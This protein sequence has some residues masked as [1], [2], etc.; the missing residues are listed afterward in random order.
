M[1]NLT[2]LLIG[3]ISSLVATAIFIG[4]S[5]L[6]RRVLLPWFSDKIYRGVRIDGRWE[7]SNAFEGE[8]ILARLDLAQKGD[9]ITGTYFHQH[10]DAE[11]DHYVLRGTLRDSYLSAT[12]HPVSPHMLDAAALLVHVHAAGGMKLEGALLGVSSKNGSVS[13][14]TNVSFERKNA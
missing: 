2:S 11:P 4:F 1:D 14:H 12:M 10:N 6:F 7:H 8:K 13:V 3:I 5:E 9:V